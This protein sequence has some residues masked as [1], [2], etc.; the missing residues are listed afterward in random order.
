LRCDRGD[1]PGSTSGQ[2]RLRAGSTLIECPF[3][4]IGGGEIEEVE[5][6]KLRLSLYQSNNRGLQTVKA[7]MRYFKF[8][9]M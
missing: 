3:K 8:D 6:V 2:K 7:S 1:K 5:G 4:P 9:Q